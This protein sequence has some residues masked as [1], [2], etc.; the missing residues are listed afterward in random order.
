[1]PNMAYVTSFPAEYYL[2]GLTLAGIAVLHRYALT[3]ALAGV[4][5]LLALVCIKSGFLSGAQHLLQ[6]FGH[7][8]VVLANLLL[9]LLGFAVLASQ[10]ERS[11]APD[12]IPA[13]LPKGWVGG[14]SLLLLVA[15]LSVFLDN[16]AG[17]M[18]GGV[19]ARHLYQDRLSVGFLAAIVAAANAGGAGSVI[20]DTTTTMMWIHG[21][22]PAYVATA[23]LGAVASILIFGIP[24]AVRQQGFQPITK[25]VMKGVKVDW[26]RLA[27]VA[28]MLAAILLTNAIGNSLH[29]DMEDSIPA[30]G[31]ALWIAIILSSPLR[32]PDWKVVGPALSGAVFL[33][34]LVASATLLPVNQL[35]SPSWPAVL[36]LG[37]LSA[38]F[39]NIPLTAVALRQGGYD[40]GLLAYAVGF[41]G[42]MIWFGSSAGVALTGL[43]P[44]ARSTLKWLRQ[45]W[46]IPVAYVLGFFIML[47]IFGWNPPPGG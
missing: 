7:E 28:F 40:W 34:A 37:F 46:E 14:F 30:L 27:T 22:S 44:E 33:V 45:A 47:A 3:M 9:L 16:I 39:D 1:M 24:A 23:F 12:V 21:I 29:P 5:A 36:G 26:T 18:I 17:A 35:P 25:A 42:S 43:Y 11:N 8:W 31:L 32:R 38:V 19:I 15:G 13:F 6:H 10:F 41:G 20:G 2:F 4:G